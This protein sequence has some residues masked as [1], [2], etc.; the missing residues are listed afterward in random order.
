[1]SQVTKYT[2]GQVGTNNWTNPN[3]ATAEDDTNY[4]TCAPSKNN[5][6]I[7]DWDFAAFSDAEV[8]VGA[9]INSVTCRCNYRVNVTSSIASLGINNGNNGSFDGETTDTSEPT[10]DTDFDDAYATAPSET[11]L[12]TAGRLVSRIRGIRGNSNNAVTFS[13]DSIALIVDYTYTPPAA[14]SF[15]ENRL[16][17]RVGDGMSTNERVK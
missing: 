14:L 10:T 13:L 3:N 12:K 1:M 15:P 4:A 6:V 9:T 8:P 16:Y 7:G 2:R 17:V 11:D 5:S